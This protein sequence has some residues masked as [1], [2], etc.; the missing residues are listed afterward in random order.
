VL[1]GDKS[2]DVRI[3][4]DGVEPRHLIVY[5]R[6]GEWRAGRASKDAQF[7]MA[8]ADHPTEDASLQKYD[9]A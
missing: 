7:S 6:D 9:S 5:Q 8:N 3:T 1:G 4:G 2:C